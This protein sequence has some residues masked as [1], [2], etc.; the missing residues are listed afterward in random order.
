[1]EKIKTLG[2]VLIVLGL[3][4]ISG[5][6]GYLFFIETEIPLYIKAGGLVVL[7]GIIILFISL[8][9]EQTKKGDFKKEDLK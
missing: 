2:V 5:Y 4:I 7:I 3:L 9:I 8:I 6:V 1:M